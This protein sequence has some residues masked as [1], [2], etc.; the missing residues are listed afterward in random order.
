MIYVFS[1]L[2]PQIHARGILSKYTVLFQASF[3]VFLRYLLKDLL[4]WPVVLIIDI[5]NIYEIVAFD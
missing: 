4:D 2:A 1:L 5:C 3:S